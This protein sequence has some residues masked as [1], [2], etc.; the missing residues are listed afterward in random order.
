M[1]TPA[2]WLDPMEGDSGRLPKAER[3]SRRNLGLCSYCGVRGHFSP[4]FPLSTNR[5][6]GDKLGNSPAPTQVGCKFSP[7]FLSAQPVCFPIKF[8][9]YPSP[10]LPLALIVSS[11]FQSCRESFRLVTHS[12]LSPGYSSNRDRVV[13]HITVT[14][15]LLTHDTY[16]EQI[17]FLIIDTP[18][19]PAVLGLPWLSWHNPVT[20][21]SEGRL[22]GWLQECQGRCLVLS[23]NTTTVESL[24]HTPHVELPEEYQDL[25]RVFSKTQATRLPPHHPWGLCH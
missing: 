15:S 19:H 6:G 9:E 20:S 11:D 13:H 8:P 4:T 22:L 23:V 3:R 17:T 24:D 21:W 25:H 10:T 1:A 5:R 14:V 2:L 7:P 16:L 12:G 18:T